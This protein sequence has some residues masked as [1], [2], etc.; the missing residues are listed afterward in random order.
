[1]EKFPISVCTWSLRKGIGEVC[2][3][4]KALGVDGMHLA[5]G[6]ALAGD[7]AYLET[8]KA[9]GMRISSTMIG[10]PW[11]NY[12]TLDTIRE[13]GGIAPDAHWSEALE[14]F[15]R[16]APMTA[17]LGAPYISF[18]AGFIDHSN[19]AYAGKF[20]E[21]M[22]AIGDIAADNGID[23]L[24]ETGQETG[25]DLHRFLE[26]LGHE[27]VFLN[28]DPANLILYNKD[29]PLNALPK[30]APWV[31]HVHAKDAVHTQPGTWGVEVPWGEG[32]V[33]VFA[34]MKALDELGCHVP[35]AVEREAGNDRV[36]DI[37]KAVRRLRAY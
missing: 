10:F 25:D 21:R 19:P 36:G 3:I 32:E 20:Y 34:F 28:L 6:P 12:S 8:A 18:H 30:L 26:E 23:V 5:L 9:S 13:T 4:L 2:D 37:A 29:T 24:M 27:H 1:M 14:L 35:V 17:A 33:N 16:A 7:A 31:R 22:R 11:E 15:K